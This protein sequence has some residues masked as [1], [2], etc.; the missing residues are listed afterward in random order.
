MEEG[1]AYRFLV[2]IGIDGLHHLFV[3]TRDSDVESG[4]GKLESSS[5]SAFKSIRTR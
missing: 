2:K 5:E 4:S 3:N 1:K